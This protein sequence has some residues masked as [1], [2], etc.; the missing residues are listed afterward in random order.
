MAHE[1]WLQRRYAVG[2]RPTAH[3][4]L[5]SGDA[6]LTAT[7]T[8]G[9]CATA[10]AWTL[11]AD[12]ELR[13]GD[14]CVEVASDGSVDLGECRGGPSRRWFVDDEGHVWSALPPDLAANL[15]FAH[16][17]CLAPTARAD[18]CGA[19]SAPTWSFAPPFVA[20]SRAGSPITATGRA[21]RLAD[22]NGDHHAD[23]CAIEP[24]GLYCARGDGA[25]G[26]APAARIDLG[27]P[28]A[29]D[30][31][32]LAFGDVDGDGLLDACGR[33]AQGILCARSIK[34]YQVARYTPQ[35]GDTEA[36][37]GTS[38]S[39]AA[40]DANG[41]GLA[42]ICGLASEGVVCSPGGPAL[43][44]NV[45]SAWPDPMSNVWP[46]DLDGDQHADWCATSSAGPACGVYAEAAL[47]TDG[48]PWAFAFH[49]VVEDVPADPAITATGD[50]D[51]DGDTDLCVLEASTI[52]CARSQG[53]GFGPRATVAVL[54]DGVTATALWLG[55]LD[56][57]GRADACVDTGTD[58]LCALL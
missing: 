51:G 26:F 39:I 47:T 37:L 49:G 10:P 50:I 29:V 24:S 38:A 21:V 25:G 44:T 40:L 36:R 12:G 52:T 19:D 18:V 5:R 41:D 23:L 55:D 3:G 45:R 13:S 27:S 2:F 11:D 9:D 28:L 8:L 1:T 6:C 20:T 22:I 42:D 58:I 17:R 14:T 16:V 33:D 43:Q 56:G 32:S 4:A 7:G 34:L 54:P 46:A 57:D 30:P 35:F 53:H 31:D 48:V 15:Y